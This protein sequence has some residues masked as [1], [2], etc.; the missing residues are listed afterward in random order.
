MK[1]V[2]KSLPLLCIINKTLSLHWYLVII[3]LP[4][5]I[6]LPPKEAKPPTT[7]LKTRNSL[8]Q[9]HAPSEVV[10]DM[11][12]V[13][14]RSPSP[15]VTAPSI[16]MASPSPTPTF[17]AQR[18]VGTPAEA[19][20]FEFPNAKA[21]VLDR[22]DEIDLTTMTGNDSTETAITSDEEQPVQLSSP[23]SSPPPSPPLNM[24]QANLSTD[25]LLLTAGD[26]PP[27]G[28]PSGRFYSTKVS[29][30]SVYRSNGRQSSLAGK[31]RDTDLDVD[32]G[33][34]DYPR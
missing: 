11:S 21:E 6:L 9:V 3:Y 33:V 15:S 34:D 19:D 12:T 32:D 13:V 20:P 8:P 24:I 23:L 4:E 1:S 22:P 7:R 5:H 18:S 26:V 10:D 2:S 31:N 27:Y 14:M 29:P 25:E 16:R 30:K 28:V 17:D